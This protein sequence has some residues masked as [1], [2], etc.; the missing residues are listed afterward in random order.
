MRPLARTIRPVPLVA[1]MSLSLC[2]AFSPGRADAQDASSQAAA[3]AL[4][5]QARQLMADG[6]FGE[7]CP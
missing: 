2:V 6:K 7:A 1:V 5:E 4:F 3:Q